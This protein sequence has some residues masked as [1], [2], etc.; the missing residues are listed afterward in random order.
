MKYLKLFEKINWED[1]D[2]E[3]NEKYDY[4]FYIMWASDA[5]DYIILPILKIDKKYY[6]F[7]GLYEDFDKYMDKIHYKVINLNGYDICVL[8]YTSLVKDEEDIDFIDDQDVI[9]NIKSDMTLVS[10]DYDHKPYE[11]YF[12]YSYLVELFGNIKFEL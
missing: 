6:L 8:D 12:K 1:W 11:R 3:E 9:N 7:V 2:Y 10:N 5:G 4:D